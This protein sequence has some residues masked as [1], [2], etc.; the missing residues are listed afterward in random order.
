[1]RQYFAE[2]KIAQSEA[3][4]RCAWRIQEACAAMI[5]QDFGTEVGPD[6]AGGFSA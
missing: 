1:L 5:V 4:K 2:K 6:F 3:L